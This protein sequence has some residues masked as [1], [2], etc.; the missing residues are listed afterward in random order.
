MC[1]DNKPYW[2]TRTLDEMTNQEWEA[3][4]DGCGICCLEKIQYEDTGE[5]EYTYVAC[6]YLDISAC[7]CRNYENRFRSAVNCAVMTPG[8]IKQLTWLPAT[9]AYRA[10]AEGRG[11]EWWHPLVSNDTQTVHDAGISIRNKAIPGKY[12]HPKD[13]EGYLK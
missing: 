4:C 10:V 8:N 9:C 3:L 7:H 13:I 6:R 12:I 11:L 5:V 1:P 2:K